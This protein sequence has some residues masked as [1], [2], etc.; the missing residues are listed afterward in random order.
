MAKEAS[1]SKNLK[2]VVEEV[3]RWPA[4]IRVATGLPVEH[5]STE[6]PAEKERAEKKDSAKPSR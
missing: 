5:N 4:W 1:L 3:R 2:D 6:E